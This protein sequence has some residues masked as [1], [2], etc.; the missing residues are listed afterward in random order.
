MNNME[1]APNLR[2]SHIGRDFSRLSKVV[3]DIV[4]LA[5]RVAVFNNVNEQNYDNAI[6]SL[7]RARNALQGLLDNQESLVERARRPPWQDPEPT[8]PLE[9]ATVTLVAERFC[10][11]ASDVASTPRRLWHYFTDHVQVNRNLEENLLNEEL[12]YKKKVADRCK[13]QELCQTIIQEA[14]RD[15]ERPWTTVRCEARRNIERIILREVPYSTFAAVPLRE[16]FRC[17]DYWACFRMPTPILL[18]ALQQ[19]CT[20]PAR[21]EQYEIAAQAAWIADAQ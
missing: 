19:L 21:Y 7:E 9:K 15:Q 4:A 16:F 13:V 3:G 2:S 8:T 10:R 5:F 14:S 6:R 20:L 1:N 11:L 18:R 12:Q 17:A